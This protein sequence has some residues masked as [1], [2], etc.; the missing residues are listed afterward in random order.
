M[1][2]CDFGGLIQINITLIQPECLSSGRNGQRH[3]PSACVA[4]AGHPMDR[5]GRSRA[6]QRMRY[7]Q[8]PG[9]LGP[10][11]LLPIAW[12]SHKDRQQDQGTT[13][14]K[15]SPVQPSRSATQPKSKYP[16]RAAAVARGK[17]SGLAP[18]ISGC[19]ACSLNLVVR[20]NY[21]QRDVP[22]CG[23]ASL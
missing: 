12:A 4:S 8:R 2:F 3:M 10:L 23:E 13:R 9:R 1:R 22:I 7:A 16:R 17:T 6:I 14:R 19:R 21:T 5:R 20:G 18:R 15:L 11:A